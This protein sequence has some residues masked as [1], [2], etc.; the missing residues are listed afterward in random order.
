MFRTV[1]HPLFL[2]SLMN[3]ILLLINRKA[4][5]R[6]SWSKA[7]A[8]HFLLLTSSSLIPDMC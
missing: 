6:A 1:L 8:F 4:I 3:Q 5:F 7:G 2:P